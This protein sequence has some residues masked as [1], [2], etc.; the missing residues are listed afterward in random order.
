M[1]TALKGINVILSFVIDHRKHF[2]STLVMLITGQS[3][4]AGATDAHIMFTILDLLSGWLSNFSSNELTNKELLVILQRIAQ[5][6][7]LN[8]IPSSLRATWDARFLSMLY[9]AI[10]THTDSGFGVEVFERVER[11]FC[12]GLQSKDS[13]FR[14][15]VTWWICTTLS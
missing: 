2:L 9:T 4:R 15:K 5:V 11:T 8:A 12:P 3:V 13:R 10:T 14:K 6:D 1:C 7:R